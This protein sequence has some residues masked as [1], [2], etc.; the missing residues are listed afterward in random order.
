MHDCSSQQAA[1]SEVRGGQID[2]S[3]LRDHRPRVQTLRIS[4]MSSPQKCPGFC[5][6]PTTGGG[7]A[8]RGEKHESFP[9]AAFILPEPDISGPVI[10]S[11]YVTRENDP[12]TTSTLGL[13]SS[14][15]SCGMSGEGLRP[16]DGP[17]DG[18][19]RSTSISISLDHSSLQVTVCARTPG[20]CGMAALDGLS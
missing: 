6:R 7:A 2:R 16:E 4:N 19:G 20:S 15:T 17:H 12:S 3:G 18:L 13:G 11:D 9:S 5:M 8:R 1:K 10:V 14:P